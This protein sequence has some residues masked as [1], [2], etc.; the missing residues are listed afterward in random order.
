MWYA[1]SFRR[2]LFQFLLL[3]LIV[4]VAEYGGEYGGARAGFQFCF[5]G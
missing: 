4:V 1:A 2:A 5:F 3:A